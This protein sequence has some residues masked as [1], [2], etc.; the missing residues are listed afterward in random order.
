MKKK[1]IG[2]LLFYFCFILMGSLLIFVVFYD[3]KS[4]NN[5]IKDSEYTKGE[6]VSIQ[7][8]RKRN[9]T[10]D[11]Y[12]YQV[13]VK[14]TVN[15]KEYITATQNYSASMHKGKSIGVYYDKNNP[16]DSIVEKSWFAKYWPIGLGILFI[17]VGLISCI[18]ILRSLNR[19][20]V[21]R[22]GI[23]EY[24]EVI[25]VK[26][27]NSQKTSEG[28]SPYKVTVEYRNFE[29]GE[30]K[31]YVSHDI[32]DSKVENLTPGDKVSIYIDEKHKD[33]YIVDVE[34]VINDRFK[35]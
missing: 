28:K 29:T 2:K 11:D 9:S 19:I 31:T 26:K 21:Y 25:S 16:S 14:Y 32:W 12:D 7:R 1:K 6:I 24:A 18:N 10:D 30:C 22:D 20:D 27:I 3:L 4:Y 35:N 13:N 5:D 15:G 34:S 17:L 23:K 33:N 8:I